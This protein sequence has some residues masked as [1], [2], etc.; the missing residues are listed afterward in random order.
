VVITY[1]A[2]RDDR[3][4]HDALYRAD[5]PGKLRQAIADGCTVWVLSN[6]VEVRAG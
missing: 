5:L 2:A 3:V 6:G 4:T 1:E